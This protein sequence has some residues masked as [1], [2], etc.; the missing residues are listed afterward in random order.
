[1]G[2]QSL[3]RE[4]HRV[5]GLPIGTEPSLDAAPT[6]KLRLDLIDEEVRE[7]HEAVEPHC[8]CG[9]LLSEHVT[10]PPEVEGRVGSARSSEDWIAIT[11]CTACWRRGDAPLIHDAHTARDYAPN[12]VAAADALADITYVTYG[13]A[14]TWGFDLDAVVREVHRSNMTKLGEDGQPIRRADGKVLK[15]PAY[16]PP[17]IEPLL[18]PFVEV[19]S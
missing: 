13:A 14:D 12:L 8:V 7:L 18:R 17:A 10:R 2:V 15:G 9:D 16:E 6:N 4:F 1:M 3:V 19:L 5:F 11:M